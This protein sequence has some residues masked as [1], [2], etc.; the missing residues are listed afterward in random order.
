MVYGFEL[1]MSAVQDAMAN[2]V[3]NN[4]NNIHFFCGDMKEILCNKSDIK[5]LEKI[6]PEIIILSFSARIDVI[7]T[8]K[9]ISKIFKGYVIFSPFP[10]K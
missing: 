5:S 6:S 7:K 9:N 8:R 10:R 1:V 4:I 2:T 3:R